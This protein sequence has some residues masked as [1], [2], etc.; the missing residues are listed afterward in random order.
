MPH[1]IRCYTLFDITKTGVTSRTKSSNEKSW[2]L[3]RN[4]QCNF[5]TILQIVSLRSQPE[6]TKDPIKIEISDPSIFG[7]MYDNEKLKSCWVFEFE[8][9]HSSVFDNYINEL[10]SLYLDCDNVPMIK[11]G[12]E[13]SLLTEFLDASPEL[14]NIHFEI[15]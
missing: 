10:G 6:V 7:F 8:V 4:T 13:D 3:R 11:C 9:Q 1:R 15:I 2:L 12:S 14:K 5:D